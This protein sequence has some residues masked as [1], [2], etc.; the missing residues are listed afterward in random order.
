[1]KRGVAVEQLKVIKKTNGRASRFALSGRL[2]DC[3]DSDCVISAYSAVNRFSGDSVFSSDSFFLVIR[4]FLV[5]MR[6]GEFRGFFQFTVCRHDMFERLFRMAAQVFVIVRA[7][8]F[9][10]LPCCHEVVLRRRQVRMLPC[11]NIFLWP[12]RHRHA[13]QNQHCREG[14][15]PQEIRFHL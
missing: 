9:R 7:S 12:L 1:M 14:S 15:A 5:M 10:F 8:G 4:F 2:H 13:G 6:V 11:V 3:F